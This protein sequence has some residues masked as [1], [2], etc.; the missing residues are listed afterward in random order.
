MSVKWNLRNFSIRFECLLNPSLPSLTDVSKYLIIINSVTGHKSYRPI[1]HYL[2]HTRTII[3]YIFIPYFNVLFFFLYFSYC[4]W[5]MRHFKYSKTVIMVRILTSN[6]HWL[7]NLRKLKAFILG[8]LMFRW[9][10][11]S[12]VFFFI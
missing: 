10:C 1:L 12:I 6:P 5:M 8:K 7:N 11:S 4:S 2:F 3:I 9:F